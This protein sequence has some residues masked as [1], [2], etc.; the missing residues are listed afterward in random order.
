LINRRD[1]FAL[2]IKKAIDVLPA[3]WRF[4]A[5]YVR[6]PSMTAYRYRLSIANMMAAFA[7]N[8]CRLHQSQIFDRDDG[9]AIMGACL[10]FRFSM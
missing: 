7:S 10:K 4:G 8:R 1:D 9:S 6:D 3:Q 5:D 2:P